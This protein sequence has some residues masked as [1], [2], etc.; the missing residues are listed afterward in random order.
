MLATSGIFIVNQYGQLFHKRK[1]ERDFSIVDEA[2][3]LKPRMRANGRFFL[4]MEGE[5]YDAHNGIVVQFDTYSFKNLKFIECL[6]CN[7]SPLWLLTEKRELYY[8]SD[9]TEDR[10]RLI[11]VGVQYL[12]MSMDGDRF[13]VSEESISIEHNCQFYDTHTEDG[14]DR[15]YAGYP[16]NDKEIMIVRDDVDVGDA[17]I[18]MN[19]LKLLKAISESDDHNR[20]LSCGSMIKMW[21]YDGINRTLIIELIQ[22]KIHA[23]SVDIGSNIKTLNTDILNYF[24]QSIPWVGGVLIEN[25]PCIYNIDGL[26]VTLS[27]NGEILQPHIKV[28][29]NVFK[30][31]SEMMKNARSIHFK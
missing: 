3:A 5:L 26:L 21:E 11:E 2:P 31:R 16:H 24:H 9:S 19:K 28:S 6:E 25:V 13:Y 22:G 27:T 8:L 30:K 20:I 4:T 17:I 14:F 12:G 29:Q 10:L 18:S 15:D 1:N 23:R 7:T